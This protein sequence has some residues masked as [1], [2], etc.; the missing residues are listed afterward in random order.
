MEDVLCSGNDK[1]LDYFLYKSVSNCGHSEDVVV[2]CSDGKNHTDSENYR[3]YFQH[4]VSLD[5]G[6][7]MVWGRVEVFNGI[8]W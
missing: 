7:F 4:N 5:E 2:T 6:I 3:L 1:N 8:D